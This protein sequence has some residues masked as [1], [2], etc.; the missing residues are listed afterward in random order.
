MVWLDNKYEKVGLSTEY[1]VL[2]S[3]VS[4]TDTA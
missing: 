1:T 4:S 3:F 2:G